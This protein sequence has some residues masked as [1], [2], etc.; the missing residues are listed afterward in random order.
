LAS[1]RAG[2]V[3]H[4][5]DALLGAH[6][7][8]TLTSAP[9]SGAD[10][11]ALDHALVRR[12]AATGEAVLRVYGWSRPCLSLGRHQRARG[13]YDPEAIRSARVD[14]V[15]RPTGGGAV[16][17][18][19][20]VTYSVTIPLAVV[21]AAGQHRVRSVY[22]AIN[23]LLLDALLALGAP[24]SLAPPR[25]PT[26]FAHSPGPQSAPTRI[27]GR[28]APIEG[29]PCFDEPAQG[30]IVAQGRKL[31]GSAQ[32]RE[33]A[34]VLQ[35]GSILLANDQHVLARLAP[36]LRPAPVAALADI[37]KPEPHSV[38]VQRALSGALERA[39]SRVGA[40]PSSALEL[41]E[42]TADA[43]HAL[44]SHYAD[45]AWTWRR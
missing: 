22:E 39:L 35:H 33:G 21:G 37:L 26:S 41:G 6:R 34:A 18:H 16:L 44:R 38:E 3:D 9:A 15:R 27:D 29:S 31:A 25:F 4:R 2:G 24:V 7:W 11:M 14:I 43:A 5:G 8:R 13:I 36:G 12:A 45:E 19:R 1:Q 42:S 17:H 32:W 20:E 30:E 10:N 28:P 40:P 23:R